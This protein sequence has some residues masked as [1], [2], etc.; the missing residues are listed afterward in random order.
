MLCQTCHQP[1]APA[2][3]ELPRIKQRILDAVRARPGISA[4]RLRDLVWQDDASG[5]PLC[6]HTLYVH[7]NQ[8]NKLIARYGIAVRA[9]RGGTGGYRLVATNDREVSCRNQQERAQLGGV[10][11]E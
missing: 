11:S 5:G 1:I 10:R 8:L 4:E 6:H 2:Q 9:P 3:L 7:I